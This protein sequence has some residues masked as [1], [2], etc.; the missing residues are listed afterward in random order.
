MLFT[1]VEDAATF[2][3]LVD[4]SSTIKDFEREFSFSKKEIAFHVMYLRTYRATVLVFG[5]MKVITESFK[6]GNISIQEY[7]KK[8]DYLRALMWKDMDYE[9]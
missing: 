7:N 1:K 8:I 3:R 2:I 9:I 6:S 5:K 4:G